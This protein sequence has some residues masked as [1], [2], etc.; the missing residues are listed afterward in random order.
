VTVNLN[1]MV[2]PL[3]EAHKASAGA[4]PKPAS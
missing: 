4:A 3:D 2:W 1:S